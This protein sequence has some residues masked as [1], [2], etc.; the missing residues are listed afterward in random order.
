MS[1]TTPR[2]WTTGEVVTAAIMNAHVRDELNFLNDPVRSQFLLPVNAIIG[3]ATNVALASNETTAHVGCVRA[4]HPITINNITYVTAAGGN[5]ASVV[6]IALYAED[7]QTKYFDVSDAVGVATGVR[8][9]AIADF[10]LEAGNYYILIGHAVY[11]T[12][13]VVVSRWNYDVTQNAHVASEPDLS[14]TL[15]V[16]D[17]TGGAPATIAPTAL[18]TVA[19]ALIPEI[20]LF[21]TAV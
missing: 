19:G 17:M 10:L 11:S 12:A 8:T 14:G 4:E 16:A 9:V 6:R 18:T 13:P 7:G 2:T 5:A 1:W 20:R 15:T 3:A 21:G